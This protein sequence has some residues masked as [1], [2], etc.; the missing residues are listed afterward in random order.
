MSPF[1]FDGEDRRFVDD[2]NTAFHALRDEKQ[3]ELFPAGCAALYAA[4]HRIQ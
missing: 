3:F 2:G 1:T 4:L